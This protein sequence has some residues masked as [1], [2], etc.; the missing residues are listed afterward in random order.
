MTLPS[1]TPPPATLYARYLAQ[2]EAEARPLMSAVCLEASRAA[3]GVGGW[4]AP[5]DQMA[6]QILPGLP[7]VWALQLG[8][9]LAGNGP[10][11]SPSTDLAGPSSLSLMS[12][13]DVDEDIESTRVV[14]GIETAAEWALRDLRSRLGQWPQ[15]AGRSGADPLPLAPGAVVGALCAALHDGPYDGALRLAVLRAVAAPLGRALA[16]LYARHAELLADWGLQP[17]R[18]TIRREPE[19]ARGRLAPEASAVAVA[20]EQIPV[21]LAQVAEQ[22]GLSR[23]M[24]ALLSRLAGPVERSIAADAGLLASM[25]N[26][27]WRLVDRLAALG[28]VDGGGDTVPLHERL[29]PIIARLEQAAQPMAVAQYEQALADA[30]AVSLADTGSA[31]AAVLA[32]APAPLLN[33][34]VLQS[35][36]RRHTLEPVLRAQMVARL[37]DDP[38]LPEV[39]QFLLGPW[40]GV[41][42]QA[43]S[44]GG[45]ETP[46]AQRVLGAVESLIEAGR[47]DRRQALT[48]A[49]VA[50]L[51]MEAE[52][53]LALAGLP[54]QRI[55]QHAAD[56]SA[57]LKTWPREA[58]DSGLTDS[59]PAEVDEAEAPGWPSHADLATVPIALDAQNP[60]DPARRDCEAWLDSLAVGDICRIHRQ[61]QWTTLRLNWRSD[62]GAFYAFANQG[63]LAFCASRRV[64][65]RL[66]L[67]GLATT[68]TRGQ[69]VRRAVDT[70]PMPLG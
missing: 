12:D 6:R 70:L 48:P 8:E 59:E 32:S 68:M 66:R 7:A 27:L 43:V 18:Y 38:L 51:R 22:A 62:N 20:S 4:V 36:E 9:R 33:E 41:V 42:L 31:A 26:P 23:G 69:W 30:E 19:P 37:R 34:Q 1:D 21:L 53:G 15:G 40:L 5:A 13:D 67:E 52:D 28:Q 29:D 46:Q 16:A 64:L 45:E 10:V 54:A 57:A 14:Q 50:C 63:G 17:A 35:V 25:D 39:K 60:D 2:C 58:L 65:A 3:S 49:E 24:Q 56:L 61:G 44:E 11:T 55:Q 47:I